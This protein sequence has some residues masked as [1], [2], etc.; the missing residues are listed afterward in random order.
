MTSTDGISLAVMN[1]LSLVNSE[2][3]EGTF[4]A[5]TLSSTYFSEA[6]PYTEGIEGLSVKS[7]YDLLNNSDLRA[8]FGLSLE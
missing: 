5:E 6:R 8:K 2:V 7:L 4:T 1:P 3:F